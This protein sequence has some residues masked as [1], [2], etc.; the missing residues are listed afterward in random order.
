MKRLWTPWRMA[1][2]KREAS[3]S[4]EECLFCRKASSDNDAAEHVLYRGMHCFVTLNLYP[5]NNGH[6]MVVPYRHVG[7]L[8]D[9]DEATLTELMVVTRKALQVLRAAYNPH[10][11]NIGMN[12]GKAGG[13]GIDEHLHQHI[14]PR[15]SGDTNYM[16]IIAQTRIVPEWIDD[17][18]T[19]LKAV[20][21]E[22]FPQDTTERKGDESK[23]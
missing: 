13:A 9:L 1:Y 23:R 3:G 5:Y 2:L 21:G 10:G 18:Y 11:F 6:M 14:V 17:T 15:W 16:A 4:D 8:D 19:L 22:L 7:A 12:L 20:W